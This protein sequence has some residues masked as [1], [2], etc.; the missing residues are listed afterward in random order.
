MQVDECPVSSIAT[1]SYL[2]GVDEGL[3]KSHSVFDVVRA[4]GPVKLTRSAG[5]VT[6]FGLVIGDAVGV[7]VATSASAASL[8]D[9]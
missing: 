7:T 3:G 8:I 2:T 5:S 6:A 1:A 9:L 4:A